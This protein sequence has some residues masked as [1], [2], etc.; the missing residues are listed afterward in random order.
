LRCVLK[1]G[2]PPQL[3]SRGFAFVSFSDHDQAEVARKILLKGSLRGRA[4]NVTWAEPTPE[5]DETT[6]ANVTTLYV[7]NVHVAVTDD[8]LRSLF[9][10]CGEIKTCGIVKNPISRESRGYAFVTYQV[11]YTCSSYFFL[12]FFPNELLESLLHCYYRD[13]TLGS[14][15][16][17][18]VLMVRETNWQQA[19]PSPVVA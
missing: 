1:K 15:C 7:G 9:A 5:P 3:V 17:R 16:G 6:M 10:Q 11:W 4:L 18:A 19:P 12:T 14:R 2:P 8:M 13:L